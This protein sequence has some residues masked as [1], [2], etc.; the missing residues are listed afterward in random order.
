MN[1]NI[2]FNRLKNTRLKTCPCV[3]SKEEKYLCPCIDFI[4][5]QK[6]KCGVFKLVD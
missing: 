4:D 1:F 2:D 5:M 6:C 3:I